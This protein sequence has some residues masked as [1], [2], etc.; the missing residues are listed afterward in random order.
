MVTIMCCLAIT[1][2]SPLD[3]TRLPKGLT[4]IPGG[5]E[6]SEKHVMPNAKP[7]FKSNMPVYKPDESSVIPMPNS[8][9]KQRYRQIPLEKLT[10]P[11]LSK[12]KK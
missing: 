8:G 12:P 7:S 1:L 10:P 5:A 9:S 6:L 3:T 2:H 4:E 11:D